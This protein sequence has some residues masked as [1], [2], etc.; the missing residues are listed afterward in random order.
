MQVEPSSQ[1]PSPH[2]D[3]ATPTPSLWQRLRHTLQRTTPRHSAAHR[4]PAHQQ[5]PP[6]PDWLIVGLGNP[7]AQY[8]NTRH[9]IGI[10]AVEATKLH[11]HNNKQAHADLAQRTT[12]THNIVY[13]RSQY[14]M[15]ESGQSLAAL[16]AQWHLPAER[17][18]IAHDELDLPPG[19][20]RI[21]LGGSHN[22]H[23]GLK[24]I[25]AA[26]GTNQYLRVRIGIGRPAAGVSV[27]DHVL[28]QLPESP[29]ITRGIALAHEALTMLPEQGIARTQNLIHGK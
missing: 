12:A 9:N 28:G 16:Q 15:N 13:V 25:D 18:I 10:L 20:V 26:L 24:S 6:A 22:G 4:T 2:Q 29:E 21:K 27:V 5:T 1:S 3:S 14:Y 8:H 19:K 23:N 7:G 17:I 11:W